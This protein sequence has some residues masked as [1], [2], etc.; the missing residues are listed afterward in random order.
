MYKQWGIQRS[1]DASGVS[2]DTQGV[3]FAEETGRSKLL[4]LLH[5]WSATILLPPLHGTYRTILRQPWCI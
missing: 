5:C 1:R 2:A 4:L 3:R